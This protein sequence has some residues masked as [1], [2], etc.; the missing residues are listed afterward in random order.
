MLKFAILKNKLVNAVFPFIKVS[1]R[2]FSVRVVRYPF[3][4]NF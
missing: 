2:K 4:D 1:N 3:K